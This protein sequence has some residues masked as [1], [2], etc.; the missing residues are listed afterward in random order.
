MVKNAKSKSRKYVTKHQ[1][2]K[3]EDTCRCRNYKQVMGG[4]ILTHL[5]FRWCSV[6]PILVFMCC[7]CIKYC[8]VS[9]PPVIGLSFLHIHLTFHLIK[10]EFLVTHFY[11]FLLCFCIL[12]PSLKVLNH[13][14]FLLF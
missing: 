1:P 8:Q 13:T 12:Q 9:F 10:L 4:K 3:L 7:P 5:K 11:V 2:D 14:E 6:V